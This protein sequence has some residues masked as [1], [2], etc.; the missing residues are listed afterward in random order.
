MHKFN[1]GG[2]N[3]P[4]MKYGNWYL[5]NCD[6]QFPTETEAYEYMTENS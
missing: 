1:K 5:P 2:D 6:V 4:Y 3:L